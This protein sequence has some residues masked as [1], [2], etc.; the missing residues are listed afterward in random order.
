MAC[1]QGVEGQGMAGAGETFGGPWPPLDISPWFQQQQKSITTRKK[2]FF[3]IVA[4]SFF[5]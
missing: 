4:S 2:A 3:Y 1:L 5:K